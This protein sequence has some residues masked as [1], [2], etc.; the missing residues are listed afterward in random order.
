[1]KCNPWRW[2]WGLVP[3]LMLGWIAIL[4]ERERIENDL[5]TR[6]MTVLERS[7]YGWASVAFEG[8]D[9]V[10]SGRAIDESEPAK[11]VA[12][13]LD[14]MGVRVVENHA[15]L[16][17]RA[18]RYAWSAI[19]RDNRIRVDGF[20]PSDK[21][22]RELIGMVKANFPSLDVDD[23][24]KLA[25]GAPPLDVWLGGVSF[26]LKQLALL[27]EGRVDLD[28]TNLSVSGDANDARSYRAAKNSLSG[29]LPRGIRLKSEAVRPPHASPYTWSARREGKEVL[30]VGHVPSETVR[31]E[32]M[33]AARRV[34][35]EV[36]VIDRM[37]AAS[38]APDGFGPAAS[39]IVAQLALLEE[40]T[41]KIRDHSAT[42][43]GIAETSAR[44]EE[45]KAAV[46]RDVLAAYRTT[47]DIRHREPAIKTI[48][49]YETSL[50]AAKDA[51][52]LR[53]YVPSEK[54]RGVIVAMVRQRF[55]G[56]PLR[57][58]LQLGA[59][60]PTG[61]EQCLEAGVEALQRLGNGRAA[62]TGRRLLITG[63]TAAEPLAQSLPGEVRGRA[64][65]ACDTDVRVT[66]DLAALQ[67]R[68]EDQRIAEQ[69]REAQRK[70]EE[71]RRQA[72]EAQR[73]Q[74][75]Q[76]QRQAEEAA[77]LRG[78]EQRKALEQQQAD[79]R[80]RA[81][82][83]RNADEAARI[84]AQEALRAADE[85]RRNE[86][87][88]RARPEADAKAKEEQKIRQ[89]VVDVCQEAMSRVARE[90]VI[91]FSRASYDLDPASYPT[92]NRLAEAANRCPT[93]VV[94]IE[95]HTDAEGT[96]ERNQL[97]SDRRANSVRDYLV[98][99]G[100]D[101]RRLVAIGYGQS[102]NIAPNNTP[103]GRARNR[104]IEFLVKM[105]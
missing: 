69:Q 53:G 76:A 23:R 61:W 18:E 36:K 17:D 81:E 38:G 15:S 16:L 58:E 52:V 10:L 70:E 86:A 13:V 63:S 43:S 75:Q 65:A 37:E 35:P 77:R 88:E 39:A 30:L 33:R 59:G 85:R 80:R 9:A 1:M 51:V 2:L 57:D 24:M 55:T 82:N 100:V 73:L 99:A 21:T 19:R 22:R 84:A 74:E 68:E 48:S 12:A 27:R 32:L 25:R 4:G 47:G 64:G 97:L 72:S 93:V 49:P 101:P 91:N 34:G 95:G 26:G 104:R 11:A 105:R 90:G 42:L 94:E 66:L 40:G 60:Q 41:G 96:I 98:R 56:R 8:R 45:I 67:S 92:L 103:E 29:Q 50:E 5:S 20:A 31:D 62:V 54:V 46:A 79:E 89:Q 14:T 6:T 28:N 83:Q 71:Q 44:A 3:I 78:Q 7:G 102:R 87:A